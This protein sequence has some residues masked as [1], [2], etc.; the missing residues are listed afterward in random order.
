[1]KRTN[2]GMI[3]LRSDLGMMQFAIEKVWM[4]VN[5]P[6]KAIS[7][8]VMTLPSHFRPLYWGDFG[9]EGKLL[10]KSGALGF[11]ENRFREI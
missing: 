3:V 7:L 4:C 10:K 11:W 1:M 5:F 8:A 2:A 6:K 9:S